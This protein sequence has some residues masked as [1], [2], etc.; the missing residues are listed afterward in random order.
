VY[1]SYTQFYKYVP[2]KNTKKR[3]VAIHVEARIN[4]F[5]IYKNKNIIEKKDVLISRLFQNRKS[6]DRK[7]LACS[8]IVFGFINE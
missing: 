3:E 5:Q 6:L 1:F 7:K 4:L 2:M 8:N